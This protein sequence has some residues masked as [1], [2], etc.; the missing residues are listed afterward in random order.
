MRSRSLLA[1]AALALAAAVAPATAQPADITAQIKLIDAQPADMDRATWKDRRRDAAR[2]LGQSRDRRAVPVLIKLAETETFDIIGE[3]AIEGL[4]NLGDPAAV[5]VLQRIAGDP[6]RD[7]TQRDLARKAL[8]KLPGDGRAPAGNAA[9]GGAGTT[10]ATAATGAA[11]TGGATSP[12]AGAAGGTSARGTG[13]AAAPDPGAAGG[14]TAAPDTSAT[15]RATAPSPGDAG[16]PGDTGGPGSALL[17]GASSSAP[18]H[19]DLPAVADD[20]LA[21]YERVTFAGGT[22][23]AGYDTVRKRLDVD[24]DVAGQYQKRIER[25]TMAWGWDAGAHVVGGYINP[26]G[27]AVTRG[28]QVDVTADGEARFYSG[29]LYGIGR[30]AGQT[31]LNYVSDVDP[32]NPNNTLKDTLFTADLQIAIGAGYGRVLDVGA[33]IRVRRLAR[34][35]EANRALGRPIDPSTARRLQLTWW[36]L[37]GERS[38]YRALVSTVAILREA[39][40]LLGEP[41]AGLSYELLNVLRDSQLYQRPS[42]LD[43][44]LLFGEGYLQR[45]DQPPPTESGRVEQLLAAASYGAQLDDDTLELSGGAYARLRLF[46]PADQ[47]SPW[48]VG[49]TA[50]ARRFTYGEHGD[51]Y[52]AL[53]VSAEIQLSSDDQ[54]N[55]QTGQRI[56]G[57][58]GFTWWL[59]S[60]S[61]FRLAAS[62]GEDRGAVVFGA[63]LSGSYGLLD[64]T[65]AR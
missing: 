15:G 60:A 51:P 27:P 46:A 21:A 62:L 38:T 53:D 58:L 12:G 44:Q 49:A 55:S 13:R 11:A 22:A 42:G 40:V 26:D 34:A 16:N 31:E 63:Q 32:N 23:N 61:G 43:L 20:A 25:P 6:A 14:R 7:R 48:A 39:G 47:P 24:A 29:P 54:M 41:D 1:V 5:P 2:K 36:A 8:A 52:G 37:R 10:G 28:L 4:G 64:G 57:Q 65:F 35:L 45:P 18:A 33:A 50:Q 17:T 56:T 59:S 9:S 30:A 19:A 3:I